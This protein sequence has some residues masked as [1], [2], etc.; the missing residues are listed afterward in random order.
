MQQTEILM[1]LLSIP[2][3]LLEEIGL[4]EMD[5]IQMGVSDGKLIIEKASREDYNYNCDGDCGRCPCSDTCEES[6]ANEDA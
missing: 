2:A 4:R 6:E 1:V 3:E 5:V